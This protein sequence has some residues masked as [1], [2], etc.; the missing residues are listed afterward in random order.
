MATKPSIDI[1]IPSWN[2]RDLLEKHLP[3][4]IKNSPEINKIIIVDDGSQD[5]TIEFLK[6]NYPDIIC[7]SHK[8]N[9]GFTISVNLGVNYSKADYIIL[10]NNDVEPLK[11]YIQSALKYFGD[12]RLFAVTFN[13]AASSWPEVSFRGKLQY[14]RGED[15]TKPRYSAWASG[16]SAIFNKK[17]WDEIG[18]LDEVYAPAYW[19][20]IDI[21]W[22]AWKMGYKIIWAPD[23]KVLHEHEASYGRKNQQYLNL[24]KQRNELLFN[25]RNI[26]DKDLISS[27]RSFLAHHSIS[28][29]GYFKVIIS[30]WMRNLSL[31]RINRF[32]VTDSGVLKIVNTPYES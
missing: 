2:A 27:H 17:I 22:R 19:E 14:T 13:E 10:L 12:P 30:A 24:I 7:L 16:G 1:I 5:D 18:G 21:G 15:K 32:T 4:T 9:I 23:T 3:N 31:K 11:G 20:D 26:S 25:W 6:K 28:H 8:D 29:P